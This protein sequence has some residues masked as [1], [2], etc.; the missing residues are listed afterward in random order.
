M[1]GAILTARIEAGGRWRR[2]LAFALALVGLPLAA[3]GIV[4]TLP[5]A[6]GLA[7]LGGGGMIVGEVLSETALPRLL[8][9][10]VLARAYGLVFP[11]SIAGIVAGSLIAG[12]LL[13]LFGLTGALAVAGLFVLLVAALLLH[14]PLAPQPRGREVAV[15]A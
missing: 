11:A 14:R 10:A 6:L 4:P 9:D 1:I 7:F 5:L 2:T 15:P 3:L 8:D 12:P 13:A